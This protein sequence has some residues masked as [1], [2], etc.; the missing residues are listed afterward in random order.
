M[1]DS[2]LTTANSR[3]ATAAPA[4][5]RRMTVRRKEREVSE[6]VEDNLSGG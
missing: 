3:E 4:I 6:V 1:I 2:N 5:K